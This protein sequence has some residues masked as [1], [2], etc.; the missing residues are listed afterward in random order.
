LLL[1]N[2]IDIVHI[3]ELWNDYPWRELFSLLKGKNFKGFCLAEIPKSPEPE[4]L[5]RYYRALFQAYME[6]A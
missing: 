4:R 2:W 5:L 3:N 1:E 6:L